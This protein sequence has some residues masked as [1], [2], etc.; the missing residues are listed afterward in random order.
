MRSFRIRLI[1]VLIA[2]ITLVSVAST[3]FEVLAHK[4]VLHRELER[5]TVWLGTSLQPYIEQA[6]TA[7]KTPDVEPLAAELKRHD[8][9]IGLAVYDAQGSLLSSSAPAAVL[10]ALPPG[11]VKQAIK[12][13]TNF[14]MF[15]RSGDLR[16][17]EEA[18]PLHVNGKPAGAL[19]VLEDDT[20]IHAEGAAV[21]R[22]TF[23]RILAF[24]V[25]I[26]AV[27]FVMVR[28]FL[29]Q[30][31]T[32]LAER[33]RRLRLGHGDD[34][35]GINPADAGLFSSLAREVETITES[36]QAARAAAA[37][38]ARLREAGENLW[39]AERLSVHV[40]QRT[41]S[42]RIFVVSNRE[43]YMHVRQGRETVAKT[44]T[45]L[46]NSI[47]CAFPPTTLAIRCGACGSPPKKRP[48]TMT[49]SPMRGCGRCA[50]S[51]TRGPSSGRPTGKH[52]NRS[53]RNSPKRC[54]PKWKAASTP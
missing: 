13:G 52:I 20:Y 33:L 39:T 22:Q 41:G 24:V 28:W 4:H 37:A 44:S 17:L 47:A 12:H 34:T 10:T 8:E 45:Q 18:V 54:S 21:W 31:I 40:R 38:E 7:G 23:W 48:I 16:W 50:T 11:P 30:P 2:G 1:L 29:M 36:L 43:P 51:R 42:S 53:T 6:L 9:A 32:R 27:T 26:V 3:Y 46:T 25:F 5:R 19:V 14:G 49:A 15:G 35:S